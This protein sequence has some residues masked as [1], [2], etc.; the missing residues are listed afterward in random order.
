MLQVSQ[1]WGDNKTT[2]IY[3]YCPLCTGMKHSHAISQVHSHIHSN[4]FFLIYWLSF[5]LDR[6]YW[7][8]DVAEICS[9]GE[10][11]STVRQAK[12]VYIIPALKLIVQLVVKSVGPIFRRRQ[13]S[14]MQSQRK[15]LNVNELKICSWIPVTVY[16]QYNVSWRQKKKYSYVSGST[17]TIKGTLHVILT[18]SFCKGCWNL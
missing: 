10:G 6:F 8:R 11:E 14:G 4:F 5:Q 13:Q 16:K 15:E 7:H 3:V 2:K 17:G 12:T 9:K 18:S 1:V